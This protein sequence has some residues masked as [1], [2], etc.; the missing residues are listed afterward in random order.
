[1][2]DIADACHHWFKETDINLAAAADVRMSTSAE[3]LVQHIVIVSQSFCLNYIII[4]LVW[5]V[6]ETGFKY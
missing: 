5:V 3:V 6:F 4:F 2:E 1:M